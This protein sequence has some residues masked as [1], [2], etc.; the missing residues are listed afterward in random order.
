MDIYIERLK[1]T[2][3]F[4]V[5]DLDINF[6]DNYNII[7]GE[8]GVGK[9]TVLNILN[10][11][12]ST[13]FEKLRDYDFE[14]IEFNFCGECITI[15]KEH[16]NIISPILLSNKDNVEDRMNN[17]IISSDPKIPYYSFEI[18][19][20]DFMNTDILNEIKGNKISNEIKLAFENKNFNVNELQS[21]IEND[22]N[23]IKILYTVYTKTILEKLDSEILFLPTYRIIE[24]SIANTEVLRAVIGE[25]IQTDLNFI[26]NYLLE[27][28]G[29]LFELYKNGDKE[30]QKEESNKL[31]KNIYMLVEYCNK[32]LFN[33][34]MVYNDDEVTLN[35][36]SH[37]QVRELN[38]TS[39][40]EKQIIFLFA[41]IFFSNKQVILI[42][43]EPE[44]SMSFEWQRL[45]LV[46]IANSGRCKSMIAATH[47]PFI[48]QNKLQNNAFSL[49]RYMTEAK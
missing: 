33:K 14:K 43:D 7:I 13:K 41:K 26:T 28:K 15:L 25:D 38:N 2:K 11:I 36:V 49:S 47:S 45:L 44:I 23:Y 12:L 40:G 32:Y 19:Q 9:T 46:D 35:I 21:F 5:Y 34:K 18:S 48:F 8:N 29:K 31:Q 24:K 3:L 42:Y 4:G 1:I 20:L 6:T 30:I 16:I 17:I 10:A 37:E 27:V 22:N 39:S